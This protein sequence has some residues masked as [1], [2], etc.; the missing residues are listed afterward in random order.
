MEK[1]DFSRLIFRRQFLLSN[2]EVEV[3]KSWKSLKLSKISSNFQVYAHPDLEV[4]T[5][6][7]DKYELILLGYVLDPFSPA[8]TSQQILDNLAKNSDFQGILKDLISISGRF[9]IVFNDEKS[10]K[11]V[12]DATAFREVYYINDNGKIACGSTPDII[13]KNL[14]V[15]KDDEEKINKFFNSPELNHRERIWIGNRTIYKNIFRLVPNHYV[16]LLSNKSIRFWPV[17]E[18]KQSTLKESTELMAQLLTG[19]FDAAVLRFPLMQGLTSGWDTRVLLSAA[20]KHVNKIHFYFIRGFKSDIDLTKVSIDYLVAKQIA[21]ESKFPLE[22]IEVQSL[23]VDKDFEK[24]YY[25]NNILARPKLL[26]V[27][28]DSYVRDMGNMVTVSGTMGNEILRLV[29]SLDRDTQDAKQIAKILKYSKHQYVIDSIQDWLDETSS[30]TKLN[31]V[32]IDLFFWEQFFG[33]WGN[34]SG[35]EQDIVR[36][37]LRP[38]NNRLFLSTYT[39]LPDKCRYRDY[40]AGHVRII[41]FLW[42]ELLDFKMDLVKYNSKM[43]LRSIGLEQFAD[44]TFQR[45]KRIRKGQKS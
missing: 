44:R 40:P 36:E 9:A 3:D 32:T 20:R 39:A 42:K 41:K 8:L 15:E 7:N 11:L 43:L 34:L 18:R 13:A 24:T 17:E 14:S 1:K 26:N 21:A 31:F 5:S 29:G 19:T 27:Y 22:I 12:N 37:E 6:Q 25:Y 23:D 45:L 38:F 33:N 35:S 2:R 30:L 4:L 10:V 16:D 28:Y